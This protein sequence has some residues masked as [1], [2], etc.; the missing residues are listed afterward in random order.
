MIGPNKPLRLYHERAEIKPPAE[1]LV[2]VHLSL[3]RPLELEE[4]R[5]VMECWA[6]G[7]GLDASIV[8]EDLFVHLNPPPEL[9]T[10]GARMEWALDLLES[11]GIVL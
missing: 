4:A 2:W 7:G 6:H 11:R 3:S 5:A 8:G 1:N 10:L 9:K